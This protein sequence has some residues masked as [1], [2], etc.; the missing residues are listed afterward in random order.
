MSGL[1]RASLALCWGPWN[2]LPLFPVHSRLHMR[3]SLTG[4][5]EIG[6]MLLLLSTLYMVIFCL[7]TRPEPTQVCVNL[8]NR[9]SRNKNK[10]KNFLYVVFLLR[11]SVTALGKLSKQESLG[12]RVSDVRLE[13][14]KE[15]S[16]P[17]EVKEGGT[18]E[19]RG[20]LPMETEGCRACRAA[21]LEETEWRKENEEMEEDRSRGLP[22]VSLFLNG[23]WNLWFSH[24]YLWSLPSSRHPS[25]HL[26][27]LSNAT[28]IVFLRRNWK[29][30]MVEPR[31][32][33]NPKRLASPRGYVDW[34][35]DFR[36]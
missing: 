27:L 8:W 16:I 6:P 28:W 24:N 21:T 18:G 10:I 12:G 30:D 7:S 11:H 29:S 13:Q 3:C 14:P 25:R 17:L 4:L 2:N 35:G 26:S 36:S 20:Q 15:D 1:P 23:N 31:P 9:D 19:W 34:D 32:V 22:H 5:H 33:I